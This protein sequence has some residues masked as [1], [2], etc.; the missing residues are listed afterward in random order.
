MFRIFK[1]LNKLE[2]D[3][4]S[5]SQEVEGLLVITHNLI[6][7]FRNSGASHVEQI[8]FCNV[9][10]KALEGHYQAIQ[11]LLNVDSRENIPFIKYEKESDLYPQ[12]IK[13]FPVSKKKKNVHNN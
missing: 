8:V 13:I 12:K 6:E 3:F 4:R 11:K 10:Y 9:L 1:R 5:L 7:D 2:K